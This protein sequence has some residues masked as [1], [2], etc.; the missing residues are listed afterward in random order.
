MAKTNQLS[1]LRNY[2]LSLAFFFAISLMANAAFADAD[3]PDAWQVTGV[4]QSS[5][6]NIRMGP[7]TQY[8]IIGTFSPGEHGLQQVTCVPYHTFAQY[9]ALTKTQ[10]EN[11]PP[12]WCLMRSADS[13]RSGWVLQR[14]IA[15][16][17][18]ST[19]H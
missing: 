2:S 8:P 10:V 17:G 5:A 6:L 11:L 13:K 9:Q 16:D 1:R 12:R 19:D 3:G 4:S 15:E 14:Y 18:T 7:G